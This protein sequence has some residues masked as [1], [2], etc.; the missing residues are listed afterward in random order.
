MNVVVT[1]VA[2]FIGS[3]LAEALTAQGKNVIGVDSFIDYYPR[4]MKQE[5]LASLTQ[6]PRFELVETPIQE[7]KLRATVGKCRCGIPPGCPSRGPSQ[8]GK[9]IFHLYR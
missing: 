8:L 2:G 1:G 3:H 6:S 5:N 9:G 4:E 7:M